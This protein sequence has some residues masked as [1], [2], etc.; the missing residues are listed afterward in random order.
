MTGVPDGY[1][2]RIQEALAGPGFLLLPDV[3]E[4]A[5]VDA[6]REELDR[7][8]RAEA[9]RYGAAALAAIGQWGYVADVL[10]MGPA[11]RELLATDQVH[12]CVSAALGDRA[13]LSIAQG[14]SLGPGEGRGQWPRRWHADLFQQREAMPEPRFCFG[15]NCLVALDEMSSVNGA[16]CV[17]PGSQAL[18]AL[19]SQDDSAAEALALTVTAPAGALLLMDGG[20]W[21]A[22]GFNATGEPRRVLKLLFVRGWIRPQLDYR[23]LIEAASYPDLTP[24][25]A[26][27]L[28]AAPLGAAG[29]PSALESAAVAGSTA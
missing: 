27:L 5:L 28:S 22:A 15:V 23:A 12:R 16:T 19:R 3:F 24:R 6:V 8:L 9:D 18:V 21:H 17:I 7:A 29:R 26:A 20:L 13:H 25:A 10:A 4:A 14:I 2:A 11:T 1:A